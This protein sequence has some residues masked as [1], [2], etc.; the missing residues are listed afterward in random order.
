MDDLSVKLGELLND[1]DTV[2]K[3]GEMAKNLFPEQE[4][5]SDESSADMLKI[6]SLINKFKNTGENENQRLLLALK[7]H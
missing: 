1:P 6:M 4:V 5:K 2:S 7:P 3:I